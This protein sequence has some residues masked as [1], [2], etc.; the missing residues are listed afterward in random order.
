MH[1]NTHAWFV[2][3]RCLEVLQERLLGPC[4]GSENTEVCCELGLTQMPRSYFC[5][6]QPSI[7]AWVGTA[8]STKQPEE[9]CTGLGLEGLCIS[10]FARMHTT[11][12]MILE[13]SCTLLCRLRSCAC[14]VEYCPSPTSSGPRSCP[15]AW[16]R[17]VDAQP[18][19]TS[20]FLPHLRHLESNCSGWSGLLTHP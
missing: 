5:R 3:A 2:V 10:Y 13:S 14:S 4:Q 20:P 1:D 17:H 18:R 8:S 12:Q 9:C 15:P 19:A 6:M 11:A 7:R 16:R